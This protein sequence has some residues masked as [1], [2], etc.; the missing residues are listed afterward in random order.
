M[1]SLN[2]REEIRDLEHFGE[3]LTKQF[4]PINPVQV[5]RDEFSIVRQQSHMSV[6]DYQSI[7]QSLQFILPT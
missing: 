1:E 6:Q 7:N 5:A 3:I 4:Q 2:Q